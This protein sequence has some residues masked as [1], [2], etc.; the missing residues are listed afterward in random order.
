MK[1]TKIRIENFKSI[2]KLEFNVKKYGKSHTT[3]FVGV[4][5]TGKT[6]ILEAMSYFSVPDD[7]VNFKDFKNRNNTKAKFVNLCFEMEF[8][9]KK[10]MP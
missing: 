6:N 1:L 4:N 7:K 3:M 2:D 8:E 10:K 5:E 9:N